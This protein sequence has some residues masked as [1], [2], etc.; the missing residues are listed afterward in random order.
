MLIRG[1]C[2]NLTHAL[3]LHSV[4]FARSPIHAL[5]YESSNIGNRSKT[6]ERRSPS[7]SDQALRID[8]KFVYHFRKAPAYITIRSIQVGELLSLKNK[9]SRARTRAKARSRTLPLAPEEATAYQAYSS[10]SSWISTQAYFKR[11]ACSH[12]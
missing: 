5:A 10:A 6:L 8:R 4:P 1:K 3:S 9:T 12:L 7:K 2:T 11:G